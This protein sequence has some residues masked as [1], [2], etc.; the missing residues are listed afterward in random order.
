MINTFNEVHLFGCNFELA[1]D[2]SKHML[3]I[4]KFVTNRNVNVIYDI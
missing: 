2:L 3:L 1:V 4:F